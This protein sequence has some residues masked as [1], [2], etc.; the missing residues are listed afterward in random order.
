VCFYYYRLMDL[1]VSQSIDLEYRLDPDEIR[2]INPH[3]GGNKIKKSRSKSVISMAFSEGWAG[4]L[5]K[6]PKCEI[7]MSWI[8]MIFLS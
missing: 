7:L 1:K 4:D 6:V 5:L 8:L 3:P 2:P